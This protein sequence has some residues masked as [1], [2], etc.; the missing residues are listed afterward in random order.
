[1]KK[2]GVHEPG[3]VCDPHGGG[4]RRFSFTALAAHSLDGRP[5][6][7]AILQLVVCRGVS[8]RSPPLPPDNRCTLFGDLRGKRRLFRHL[9]REKLRRA[10]PKHTF[11]GGIGDA[12]ASSRSGLTFRNIPSC[13]E[14]KLNVSAERSLRRR[15]RSLVKCCS[16]FLC[17]P[18]NCVQ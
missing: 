10:H 8:R 16:A 15:T 13:V 1:M 5:F 7:D 4:A 6:V 12:S 18:P 14:A 2:T 9:E 11:I 17:C 3:F